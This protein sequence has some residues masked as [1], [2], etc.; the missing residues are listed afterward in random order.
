V[1]VAH[2]PASAA[3]HEFG[4][5]TSRLRSYDA[6]AFAR[7][8]Q[9]LLTQ[10]RA[11]HTLQGVVDLAVETIGGCDYAG[12]TMPRRG[13]VDTPA[14]S[15]PLVNQLDGWQYELREGPCAWTRGSSMTSM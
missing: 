15:D 2:L 14:A 6:A 5:V 10:P 7:I 1:S 8:S 11:E 9:Q 12:I 3:H 4:A 13:K